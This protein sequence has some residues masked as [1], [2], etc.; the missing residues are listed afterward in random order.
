MGTDVGRLYEIYNRSMRNI[1]DD[2]HS[3]GD[4]WPE[5]AGFGLGHIPFAN[6]FYLKTPINSSSEK[7]F[8]KMASWLHG[9][10]P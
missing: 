8:G 1:G 7:L 10:A 6:L 5:L 4:V 9:T 3:P 2:K